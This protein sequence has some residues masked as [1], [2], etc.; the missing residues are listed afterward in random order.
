MR[1]SAGG[2]EVRRPSETVVLSMW[3]G[4]LSPRARALARASAVRAT[5]RGVGGAG[6]GDGV[7]AAALVAFCGASPRWPP[8]PQREAARSMFSAGATPCG[9]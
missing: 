7:G 3:G 5:P 8:R 4:R 6:R 1:A 9:A 2:S